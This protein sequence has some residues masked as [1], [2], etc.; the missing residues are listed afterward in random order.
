M[1]NKEIHTNGIKICTILSL[2]WIIICAAAGSFIKILT[3][4]KNI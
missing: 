3:I 4:L 2:I 1:I